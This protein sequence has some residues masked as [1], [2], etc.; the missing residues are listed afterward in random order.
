MEKLVNKILKILKEHVNQNN[1]EVQLNQEEILR[2]LSENSNEKIQ[3]ELDFKY[4]LNK[5][6]LEENEEFIHM[7]IELSEF[8]DKYA[9]L[10]TN[11]D[12]I[13]GEEEFE[14]EESLPYFN[15]TISGHLNF[16]I[17]HPQFNNPHFFNELIKYYQDAENYEMCEQLL[18]IRQKGKTV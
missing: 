12:E 7:Q 2:M 1:K 8:M 5:E 10:F 16:D 17:S 9:H 3:K 11:A 13:E 4:S 6:L 15:K 18:I 14:D